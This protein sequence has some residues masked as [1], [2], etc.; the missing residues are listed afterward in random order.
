MKKLWKFIKSSPRVFRKCKNMAGTAIFSPW[1]VFLLE[2]K[3]FW[4]ALVGPTTV[5]TRS[6]LPFAHSSNVSQSHR[7]T[8]ESSV[9]FFRT[10]TCLQQ[11]LWKGILTGDRRLAKNQKRLR[12]SWTLSLS[13]WRSRRRS[14]DAESVLWDCTRDWSCVLWQWYGMHEYAW[15]LLYEFRARTKGSEATLWI[16]SPGVYICV[17]GCKCVCVPG[18]WW[19]LLLL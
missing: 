7:Y 9:A 13:L 11:L 6:I 19:L 5:W 15:V 3:V 10:V 18:R 8:F 4:I 1:E 2:S 16:S 17:H 12:I 14:K